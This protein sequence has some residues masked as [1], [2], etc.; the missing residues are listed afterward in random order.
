MQKKQLLD[1]CKRHGIPTVTRDTKEKLVARIRQ[2]RVEK[3]NADLVRLVQKKLVKAVNFYNSG[4][5]RKS[6]RYTDR[7]REIITRF[8]NGD[9]SLCV[10][11]AEKHLE[12]FARQLKTAA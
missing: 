5:I 8:Y 1:V 2:F 6:Q 11:F 4:K 3:P 9:I 10:Q 12:P 7:V